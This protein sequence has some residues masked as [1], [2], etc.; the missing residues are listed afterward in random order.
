MP[1]TAV[2][3]NGGPQPAE[4]RRL[5]DCDRVSVGIRQARQTKIEAVSGSDVVEKRSNLIVLM[6]ALVDSVL[7]W[8]EKLV[9]AGT[10][11][12]G[13]PPDVL[14]ALDAFL[15][16]SNGKL[17]IV[18]PL[19]DGREPEGEKPRSVLVSEWTLMQKC[20]SMAYRLTNCYR[21]EETRP[22]LFTGI[23]P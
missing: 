3:I 21:R 19:R 2:L 6:R 15:A 12:D 13:L 23:S 11:D 17:L 10:R 8:G 9:Y 4:G 1:T 20:W 7:K 5:I 18:L 16:Q 14:K 22:S